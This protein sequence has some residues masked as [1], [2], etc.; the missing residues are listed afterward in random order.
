[1]SWPAHR[2]GNIDAWFRL[3]PSDCLRFIVVACPKRFTQARAGVDLA[4][5]AGCTVWPSRCC[6][7][8]GIRSL[9]CVGLDLVLFSTG[10]AVCP[11]SL[12]AI[13]KPVTFAILYTI[14]NIVSLSSTAFLVGPVKQLKNMFAQ[15]RIIATIV[16]LSAMIL[17]LVVAIVV[18]RLVALVESF[19]C[20]TLYDSVSGRKEVHSADSHSDRHSV[21]CSCLVRVGVLFLPPNPVGPSL[22]VV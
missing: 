12:F 15:K 7:V 19:A 13:M 4:V 11:Q 10:G 9:V 2:I 14:G 16:F 8:H 5:L 21:L 3:I 20:D 17:T 18:R 1:V 22:L 6:A